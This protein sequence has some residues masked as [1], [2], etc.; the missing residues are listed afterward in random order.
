MKQAASRAL[1]PAIHFLL[2]PFLAYS[3]TLKMKGVYSSEKLADFHQA[4]RHYIPEDRTLLTS[5]DELVLNFS[6]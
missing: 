5:F 1:L 2:V 3:S 4:I 6:V